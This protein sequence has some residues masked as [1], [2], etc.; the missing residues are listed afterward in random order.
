MHLRCSPSRSVWFQ[1]MIP[2]RRSC[3]AV[4]ESSDSCIFL[5]Q[6]PRQINLTEVFSDPPKSHFRCFSEPLL[7][8]FLR[9]FPGI[10][11]QT[12]WDTN[13]I[14]PLSVPFCPLFHNLHIFSSDERHPGQR[15]TLPQT[16]ICV[17]RE[18]QWAQCI[19]QTSCFRASR[20]LCGDT[21]CSSSLLLPSFSP[22]E[23]G[24]E[25]K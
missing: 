7:K 25:S 5:R 17:N 1:I 12:L 4:L 9:R 13:R 20:R 23:S 8:V 14:P 18:I 22:P 21:L 19:R 2:T 24:S 11:F 15:Q 16:E 3:S 10:G 6:T